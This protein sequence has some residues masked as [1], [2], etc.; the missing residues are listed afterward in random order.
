MHV[1]IRWPCCFLVFSSY[2]FFHLHVERGCS[3]ICQFCQHA[4]TTLSNEKEKRITPPLRLLTQFSTD[5]IIP[6]HYT[7][8]STIAWICF[9]CWTLVIAFSLFIAFTFYVLT[10]VPS[11]FTPTVPLYIVSFSFFFLSQNNAYY[12]MTAL[13][14]PALCFHFTLVVS[15]SFKMSFQ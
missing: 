3:G 4:N 2:L 7:R 5:Y 1:W 11:F 15:E 13:D 9:C 14:F 6:M 12:F 10:M 8:N